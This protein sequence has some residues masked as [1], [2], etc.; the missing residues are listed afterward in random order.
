MKTPIS[1]YGGKQRLA[2]RI[3]QMIPEHKLY[4]EPFFGGGA[5]FFAKHPSAHEVIN[6]MDNR[7]INFYETLQTDFE[8]LQLKILSTLHSEYSYILSKHI[9]KTGSTVEYQN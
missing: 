4:C 1:Y 8:R 2:K 6:D 5:V 3:V 9:L 7:V